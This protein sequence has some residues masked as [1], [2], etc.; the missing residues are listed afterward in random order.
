MN[1]SP[2]RDFGS[3]CVIV[4]AVCIGT[5]MMF[6]EPMAT[7]LGRV[8]ASIAEFEA[9]GSQFTESAVRRMANR[10]LSALR[11]SIKY[12]AFRRLRLSPI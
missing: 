11:C 5:W 2:N 4:L 10:P 3:I 6:V 8:E 9:G 7:K 1:G 12:S